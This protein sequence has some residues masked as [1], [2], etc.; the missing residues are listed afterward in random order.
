MWPDQVRAALNVAGQ[1]VF[2]DH[3]P[4]CLQLVVCDGAAKAHIVAKRRVRWR[5]LPILSGVSRT[6]TRIPYSEI[7]YCSNAPLLSR[8]LERIK[9][10]I[11]RSQKTLMLVAAAGFFPDR[12]RGIVREEQ[13]LFRSSV[14]AAE[15]LDRLY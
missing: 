14:F 13:T 6:P 4:Y 11:L 15:E 1:R 2:D 12:P 8:H 3:A 5:P 9:L 10:A 7:L